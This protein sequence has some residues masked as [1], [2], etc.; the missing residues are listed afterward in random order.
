MKDSLVITAV[1]GGTEV[2]PFLTVYAVLP[3]SVAFLVAFSFGSQRFSRARLFYIIITTFLAF[4]VG[5]AYLYPHHQVGVLSQLVN[6]GCPIYSSWRMDHTQH[7]GRHPKNQSGHRLL[8][9]RRCTCI[10]LQTA[11]QHGCPVDLRA[12]L[13]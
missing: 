13:A 8:H 2:I 12:A 9:C 6:P 4:F 3:L 5:F 1:G 7:F 10:C 11:W